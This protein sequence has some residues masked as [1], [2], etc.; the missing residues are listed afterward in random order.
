MLA[1]QKHCLR[2]NTLLRARSSWEKGNS[3]EGGWIG[4]PHHG[5]MQKLFNL[6]KSRSITDSRLEMRLNLRH[7]PEESLI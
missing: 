7:G 3:G 4:E 5:A 6:K 1:L 2:L